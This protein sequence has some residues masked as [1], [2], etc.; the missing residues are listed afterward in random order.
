MPSLTVLPGGQ[1][2]EYQSPLS[3]PQAGYYPLAEP[4]DRQATARVGLEGGR[5][6]QLPAGIKTACGSARSRQ[7]AMC[8]VARCTACCRSA[9]WKAGTR[10]PSC[11]AVRGLY[12]AASSP[13]IVRRR[14]WASIADRANLVVFNTQVSRRLAGL[15]VD[16]QPQCRPVAVKHCMLQVCR[17]E[18]CLRPSRMPIFNRSFSTRPGD[19]TGI[20]GSERRP[21]SGRQVNLSALN[22]TRGFRGYWS[23][24]VGTDLLP[25]SIGGRE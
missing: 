15:L 18:G 25:P 5:P 23:V 2:G 1:R 4:R 17:L 22:R 7:P 9:A 19:E 3:S 10:R 20:P 6:R 21:S 12:G 24:E 11:E 13:A 14:W 16:A 8:R